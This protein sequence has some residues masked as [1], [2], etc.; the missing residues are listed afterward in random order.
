MKLRIQDNSLRLRLT[1]SEVERL[2]ERGEVTAAA[3]F[4]H[5]R[6]LR[7]VVKSAGPEDRVGA[8]FDAGADAPAGN[9]SDVVTIVVTVPAG[10]V[11]DWAAS[12]RVSIRGSEPLEGDDALAILVEKDFA[13]LSP[14][15]GEDESD[16]F[17]H[18]R[19]G[20]ETC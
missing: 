19:Q 1:R 12:D 2:S 3:G 13:C 16:M 4:A 6:V 9:R 7:Y 14:R 8:H 20:E 15:E 10:E 5:G 11:R 18:P 17:P